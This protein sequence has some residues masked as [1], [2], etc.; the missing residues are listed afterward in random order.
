[1]F[2]TRNEGKSTTNQSGQ[3]G[4]N[5]PSEKKSKTSQTEQNVFVDYKASTAYANQH[6]DNSPSVIKMNTAASETSSFYNKP[7]RSLSNNNV[8][9]SLREKEKPPS[10]TNAKPSLIMSSTKSFNRKSSS[11][12]A[13]PLN[14]TLRRN[15]TDGYMY[16]K[17]DDDLPSVSTLS[18]SIAP[19]VDPKPKIISRNENEKN[20][21]N[22]ILRR[23]STFD[24]TEEDEKEDYDLDEDEDDDDDEDEGEDRML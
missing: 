21:S 7:S 19:K 8:D 12:V 20:S 6:R 16:R 13:K 10:E 1:V 2:T 3:N 23:L 9:E 14:Q 22:N 4:R 17:Y 11:P 18:R 15:N 5:S 24:V